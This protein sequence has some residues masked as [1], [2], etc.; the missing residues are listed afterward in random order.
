V[1]LADA[2]YAQAPFFNFLLAHGKQAL[3]VL[4]DERRDVY[5]D[6]GELPAYRVGLQRTND[7]HRSMHLGP[8]EQVR[9]VPPRALAGPIATRL[10]CYVLE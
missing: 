9:K 6:G 8:G 1:V 3:V 5:Q 2:L 7:A 10:R 4:K